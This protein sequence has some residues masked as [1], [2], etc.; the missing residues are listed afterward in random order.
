VYVIYWKRE[1]LILT[2]PAASFT[3]IFTSLA[4]LISPPTLYTNSFSSKLK[5]QP[6][7]ETLSLFLLFSLSTILLCYLLQPNKLNL[8][9]T[10][11]LLLLLLSRFSCVRLCATTKMAA[12]QAP[13]LLEFSRQEHWSGLPFPSPMHESEK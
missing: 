1:P 2:D 11:Q 8:S 10:P 5:R 12:H 7:Q 13:L 3:L 4:F 9:L 6:S